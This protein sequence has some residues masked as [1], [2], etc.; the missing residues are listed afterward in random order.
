MKKFTL[1]ELL[2]VVA[3]IGILASILMPS[4][5]ESRAKSQAAV[6]KSNLHQWGIAST[7]HGGDRDD[8]VAVSYVR[9]GSPLDFRLLNG[10]SSDTRPEEADWRNYGTTWEDWN[11]YGVLEGNATCPA[12]EVFQSGDKVTGSG[13]G[14]HGPFTP[15]T[16]HMANWGSL[17]LTSYMFMGGAVERGGW[18]VKADLKPLPRTY[19]DSDPEER[20][21]AADMYILKQGGWNDLMTVNHMGDGRFPKYQGVLYLDGHVSTTFYKREFAGPDY[22]YNIVNSLF[23]FWDN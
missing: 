9:S 17:V 18:S 14:W 15:P 21:L 23:F 3:I 13:N 10:D 22:S 4:L 16:G 1:I 5:Q 11:D 6:C 19:T 20:A 12:V 8:D 7:L 2:V